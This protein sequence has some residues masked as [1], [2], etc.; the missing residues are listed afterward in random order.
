MDSKPKGTDDSLP[1]LIVS[2][3][4]LASEMDSK[5]K[6]TDDLGTIASSVDKSTLRPKWTQSRKALMTTDTSLNLICF[7]LS[8]MDSKPKGTDDCECHNHLLSR[9][10]IVR[11]GLKAER[12]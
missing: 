2:K 8:E 9:S 4:P 1:T 11:N 3:R 12:H 7:V 5:P 10:A 6:G